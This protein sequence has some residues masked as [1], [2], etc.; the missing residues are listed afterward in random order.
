MNRCGIVR[1]SISLALWL[2]GA[3]IAAAAVADEVADIETRVRQVYFEGYP[4][5]TQGALASASVQRLGEMLRDPADE[6]Y[7]S[8]IVLALGASANTDA[9]RYLADFAADPPEGEVSAALYQARSAL[10]VALG[11]LAY[12]DPRAFGLVEQMARDTRSPG[13]RFQSLQGAALADSLRRTAVTGLA[14][15]GRPEAAAVLDDLSVQAAQRRAAAG[16]AAPPDE[17]EA[18]LAFARGLHERAVAEGPAAALRP[19][20][21]GHR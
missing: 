4:I 2:C 1:G 13:W 14:L 11:Q 7:W 8:N 9:Y 3:A 5:S 19:P 20:T 21:A 18:H 16:A 10:P 15:S 12:D 6:P 17:W